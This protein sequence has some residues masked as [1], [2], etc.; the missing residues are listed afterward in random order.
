MNKKYYVYYIL[1]LG[2]VFYGIIFYG[3][4]IKWKVLREAPCS[5]GDIRLS[6]PVH[7]LDVPRHLAL[8]DALVVA[9]GAL[10]TVGSHVLVD[11]L[12]GV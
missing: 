3:H 8:C 7:L 11:V 1:Y 6:W 2:P 5:E 9:V 10:R 12:G 4:S